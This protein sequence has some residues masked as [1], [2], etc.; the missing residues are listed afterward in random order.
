MI[1]DAVY[2]SALIA[3]VLFLGWLLQRLRRAQGSARAWAVGVPREWLPLI[4]RVQPDYRRLPHDLQE[5]AQSLAFLKINDLLCDGVGRYEQLPEEIKLSQGFHCGLLHAGLVIPPIQEIRYVVVGT[6]DEM[7]AALAATPE[8]W[9]ESWLVTAWDETAQRARHLREEADPEVMAHF[10]RLLPKGPERP[11]H[12]HLY[13]AGWAESFWREEH[14]TA[15][16][17]LAIAPEFRT[18][19]ALFS[20]ASEVFIR[21]PKTLLSQHPHLYRGLRTYYRLDPQHWKKS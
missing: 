11:S 19:K 14:H 15:E 13:Y 6:Y 2:I 1:A 16:P 18:D 20:A 10:R 7:T 5:A 12:E 9:S 4:P 17:M 21:F 3:A 8:R